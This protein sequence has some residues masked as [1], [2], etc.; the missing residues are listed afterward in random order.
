MG[1]GGNGGVVGKKKGRILKIGTW[2][3]GGANQDLW[4]K[5]NEIEM[6]LLD[7]NLDCLGIK[8]ANLK[9]DA[10]MEKVDI[11]GYKMVCVAGIEHRVKK[12]SRVVAF[13]KE[14]LSYGF[15]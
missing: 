15:F 5:I 11:P 1:G 9:K 2:N 13:V 3:K 4:K 7:K 14:K 10:A 8:E 12:N 6:I